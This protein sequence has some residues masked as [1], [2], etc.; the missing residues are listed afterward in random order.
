MALP[1]N[2]TTGSDNNVLSIA[3]SNNKGLLIRF[4]NEQVEDG[5]YTLVI[6]YLKDNNFDLKTMKVDEDVKAQCSKLYELGEFVDENIKAKEKYEI[7]EWIEPL[8]N[9]VYGNIDASDIDAPINTTGIYRFSIWL[10]YLYQREKF[11]DAMKLIGERIAPLLINVSYQ[12]L[13]DDDRPKNFDKALMG[14]LD[15]INVVMEM[16]LPTSMANSEA[17]LSNLEV[18]FDYVVEDPHVGNDYKTQ[19]SIGMFNTFIAN[20]D[21]PKAFEFYG[22]NSE[23]IP[24][25]NMAVYESF[26]E[27][28]R[29]VN[30]AQ[31]TSVLSRNVMTTI[32]KQEIYNKRIDTLI[33][34]VSAFIKKVYLYIENEPDM[35]KNLQILGAGAQL[36]GKT[37]IF[38]GLYEYNLVFYECGI[39]EIVNSDVSTRSW[40]EKYEILEKL[41]TTLNVVF[42]GYNVYELSNKIEHQYVELTW[43]ND[44]V[45]ANPTLLKLFFSV[46]EK[47]KAFKVRKNTILEKSKTNYEIK[48]MIDD[49]QKTLVFMAAEDMIVNGL[50][51]GRIAIINSNYDPRKAEKFLQKDYNDVPVPAK[52][53]KSDTGSTGGKL[54]GR[55]SLPGMDTDLKKLLEDSKI[56]EMLLKSEWLWYQYEDKGAESQ[57]PLEATYSVICLIKAVEKLLDKKGAGPVIKADPTPNKKVIITKTGKVI[58]LSNEGSSSPVS[59]NKISTPSVVENINNIQ[60]ALKDKSDENVEYVKSYVNDWLNNVM[61]V[62]FDKDTMLPLFEAE[63]LRGKTFQVLKKLRADII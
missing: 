2:I 35:K 10:I 49:R 37:N 26:K 61:K 44:Y 3:A 51:G 15:L 33:S 18:L 27:L 48:S 50:N 55:S 1:A 39:K 4:L 41:Y 17:Y 24:I 29:N 11:G 8:F 6:D 31:D 46:K 56:E 43:I 22:L 62:K 23:F 45:N 36:T 16:G 38:E 60:N 34:E 20:N 19:L 25:D 21:Y 57:T 52:Y 63:E 47:I 40:E 30:N 53:K 59:A 28:I 54:F 7:D 14:Y 58:E 32:T 42:D 9:F 12:I 5:F 13:E